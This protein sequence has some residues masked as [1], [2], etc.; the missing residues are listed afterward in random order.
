MEAFIHPVDIM[1]TISEFMNSNAI[2]VFLIAVCIVIMFGVFYG[3]K[4]WNDIRELRKSL[5]DMK[6]NGSKTLP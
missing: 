4:L 6:G 3:T 2:V 5:D 1:E